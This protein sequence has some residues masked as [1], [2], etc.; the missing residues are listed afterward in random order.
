MSSIVDADDAVV[1][2]ARGVLADEAPEGTKGVRRITDEDGTDSVYRIDPD[3]DPSDVGSAESSG[4]FP[5]S[6]A[7]LWRADHD[8]VE[9]EIERRGLRG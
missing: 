6:E 8:L 9:R 4:E 5:E 1:V 7:V 2:A 3:G